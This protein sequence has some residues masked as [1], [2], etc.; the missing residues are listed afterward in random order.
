V[1]YQRANETRYS[2]LIGPALGFAVMSLPFWGGGGPGGFL[3]CV[4]VGLALIVFAPVIQVVLL[5]TNR[6]RGRYA[7]ACMTAV[8]I[9][10]AAMF[11]VALAGAFNSW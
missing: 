8:G 9:V 6:Y 5:K 11:L 1:K 4:A 7:K 3:L 2:L 10:I